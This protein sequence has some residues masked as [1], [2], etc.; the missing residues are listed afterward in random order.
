MNGACLL[1]MLCA[2]ASWAADV[3]GAWQLS[4]VRENG[5][6]HVSSL[7]LKQDGEKVT[8]TLTSPLGNAAIS[9]GKVSGDDISFL[10]VRRA[11]YDNISVSYTGKVEGDTLMLHMQYSGRPEVAITG[12]RKASP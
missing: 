12:K 4:Y 10:V 1:M 9:D 3:S 7:T 11:Q 8:G 2:A 5:Q 6:T